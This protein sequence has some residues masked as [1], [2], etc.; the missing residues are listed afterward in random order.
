MSP[1]KEKQFAIRFLRWVLPQMEGDTEAARVYCRK[2]W[3]R[4]G[5]EI[6]RKATNQR[7]CGNVAKLTTYCNKIVKGKGRTY[8]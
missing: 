2:M 3:D 4:Y 6:L 5:Y 7:D 8:K 1:M